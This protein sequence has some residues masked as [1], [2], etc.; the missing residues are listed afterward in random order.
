MSA[1]RGW[2]AALAIA[3]AL[4][5]LIQLVPYGRDHSPPAPGAS[6]AWDSPR[7]EQLARRA[8]FDCHS[9]ETNWPWYASIAPLSWRIQTHVDQGRETLNF[10]AFD[11]AG[12]KVRE[13]AG[14]AA[15]TVSKGEMP[16]ADYVLMHPEARLSAAER[17]AL[18]TGFDATFA[19]FKEGEHASADV[20]GSTGE[21]GERSGHGENGESE[22]DD[23]D[24]DR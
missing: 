21:A 10:S 14:E 13:A 4:F 12:E 11:P 2:P 22:R 16:P 7:T 23:H 8:C 3:L 1:P 9:N 20:R 5:T 15:E 19:A 18:E 6:A 17:R 24:K